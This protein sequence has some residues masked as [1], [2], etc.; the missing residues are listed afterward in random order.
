MVEMIRNRIPGLYLFTTA[1]EIGCQGMHK[2]ASSVPDCIDQAISFDRRGTGSVITS[3]MEGPCCSDAF[4]TE[5]CRRLGEGFMPDPT[6][7]VTDSA[8][9]HDRL[10]NYTNISVGY[11]HE[12]SPDE[13][14]DSAFL[15]NTLIPA[16]LRVDWESLPSDPKPECDPGYWEPAGLGVP[17]SGMEDDTVYQIGMFFESRPHRRFSGSEVSEIVEMFAEGWSLSD[18]LE[19]YPA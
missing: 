4:A 5:L 18:V 15:L 8:V 16:V 12:H 1:E 11:V 14:V 9:L 19:M 17:V 2:A 10:V 7:S 13:M 6:G 3:M